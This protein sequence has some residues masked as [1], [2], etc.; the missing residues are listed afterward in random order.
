MAIQLCR[1]SSQA[2]CPWNVKFARGVKEPRFEA[3]PEIVWKDAQALATGILAMSEDEL[4]TVFRGLAMTWEKLAGLRP[5]A[6]TVLDR[7]GQ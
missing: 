2:C 6:R 5:D 3:R 7:A 1:H 4:R